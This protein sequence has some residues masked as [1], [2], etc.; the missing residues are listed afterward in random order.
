MAGA[1][2]LYKKLCDDVKAP[3]KA[4]M[5]T[6]DKKNTRILKLHAVFSIKND[7]SIPAAKKPLYKPWL[8]AKP[9]VAEKSTS[10]KAPLNTFL[11]A[12]SQA[13]I[14]I[15]KIYK[16]SMATKIGRAHV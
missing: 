10:G 6:H 5:I 12:V 15:H 13:N 4:A 1:P 11:P 9:L 8:A 2:C 7:Q 16:C 3:Y 14:S